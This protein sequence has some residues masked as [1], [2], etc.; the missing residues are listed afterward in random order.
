[1]A[2]K[3]I[4]LLYI[5]LFV[6]FVVFVQDKVFAQVGCS[7]EVTIC[8][9]PCEATISVGDYTC[10]GSPKTV[11]FSDVDCDG[12]SEECPTMP[13][14][15]TPGYI[16][17]LCD[18]CPAVSNPGQEDSDGDNF[19]DACGDYCSGSGLYDIDED[20]LCDDDDNCPGIYNPDQTDSD[21]D[22]NG[23]LCL[24]GIEKFAPVKS[25]TGSWYEIGRQVGQTF[26]DNIIQ[27]GEIMSDVLSY[28]AP[29][30]WTPQILYDTTLEWIPQSVQQHMQGMAM[31]ITEVRP[32]SYAMA[33]DL[34]LTQ[35]MAIELINMGNNMETVPT[36][37]VVA[38][39]AFGV[40]SPAGSFLGHN[41]DAQSP[42][43]N[44]NAIMYW[45]P[46]N[47]D[48]AYLT[49]DP[50]G[51]ADVAFGLNEKGIAV[52]MNAGN[53]NTDAVMGMYANFLIR[54]SMEHAAT[55]EEAVGMFED[56]IAAGNT[57]SP[58]GVIIHYMDFNQ[59][60]MAKIQ[61]RSEAIE[62]TYG[63]QSES[64]AT[65]IGSANHFVGDFSPDPDYYYES[66]E[67]RYN[68][69]ME[70]MEQVQTFDL[71]GSWSIL[72]DTNG[73]EPNNNTI[74]RSSTVFG[75]IMTANGIYYTISN[76]HEYLAEYGTPQFVSLDTN[77]DIDGDGV[78]DGDDECEDTPADE[79]VDPLNGCSIEQLV[80]CEGPMN[81]TE[82]WKNHGKYVSTL[83]K[84]VNSF[85][86]QGLITEGEKDTLM[87]EMASSDC[88][89]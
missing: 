33:W 52:T 2:K 81:T 78:M 25:F 27:F 36:P 13:D 11:E 83:A 29:E 16:N 8:S 45:K 20:G 60:T 63:Q 1:M 18:N 80:P 46:T 89:K 5:A 85:V 59:N 17:S 70:L 54:Y 65:Y 39:T 55:L 4:K 76:P 47:G 58:T 40:A 73:G 71:K 22:G 79:T 23:D 86:K 50:P 77:D 7:I 6:L 19:P 57:F 12:I 41:T 88:G 28:V 48:Y 26:P 35:N 68:R 14:D 64:S 10:E 32:L 49:M 66:S 15:C 24:N 75:T 34:V 72:S 84:N 30:G 44:I 21:G 51:W 74:S 62:V 82:S 43:Y 67:E 38:C 37:E 61:L 53:P 87:G 3:S 56:H 42:G 69:L 31:G 9:N